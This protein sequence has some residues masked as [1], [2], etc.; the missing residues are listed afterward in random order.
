MALT[1]RPNTEI[2]QILTTHPKSLEYFESLRSPEAGPSSP[3]AS[4]GSSKADPKPRRLTPPTIAITQPRRLPCVS[5]ATRVAQ[6][7]AVELGEEVG[8]AVRFE[9][10]ENFGRRGGAAGKRRGETTVR[11]C[12]EG[13]LLR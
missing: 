11:F 2:P 12:T 5:L 7:M 4:N 3:R 1:Y 13:V 6:E 9:S 8:Y 10:K